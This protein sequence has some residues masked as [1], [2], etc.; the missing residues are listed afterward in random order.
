MFYS[1]IKLV[2]Q[3][4]FS[5]NAFSALQSALAGTNMGLAVI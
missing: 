1:K 5:K 3:N 4:I 2:M